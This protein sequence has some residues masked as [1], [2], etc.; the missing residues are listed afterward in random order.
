[1]TPLDLAKQFNHQTFVT[2]LEEKIKEQKDAVEQHMEKLRE[3]E[4]EVYRA[5]FAKTLQGKH[6]SKINDYFRRRDER[7]DEDERPD[8]RQDEVNPRNPRKTK[9]RILDEY[10]EEWSDSDFPSTPSTPEKTIAC[11]SCGKEEDYDRYHCG[12]CG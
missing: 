2:L 1:M 11:E 9:V 3:E 12:N 5:N 10:G 7:P 8:G 6:Q 4:L